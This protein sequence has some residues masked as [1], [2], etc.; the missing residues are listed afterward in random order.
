VSEHCGAESHAGR[1]E[2][3]KEALR[4]QDLSKRNKLDFGMKEDMESRIGV[5][6]EVGL[7]S[8]ESEVL[9]KAREWAMLKQGQG[10]ADG[11]T[12]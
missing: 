4:S 11:W 12:R 2:G 8:G 10:R 9:G 5:W 3:R 1:T 6:S 7:G